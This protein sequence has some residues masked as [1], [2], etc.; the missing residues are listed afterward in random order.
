M[1]AMPM[2]PVTLVQGSGSFTDPGPPPVAGYTSWYDP[3]DYTTVTKSGDAVSS[4]RD[5]GSGG[6]TLTPNIGMPLCTPQGKPG[7]SAFYSNAGAFWSSN[8]DMTDISSSFF[9]VACNTFF[10]GAGRVLLGPTGNSGISFYPANT[11]QLNVDSSGVIQIARMTAAMTVG[12]PY[13]AGL[14]LSASTWAM[15]LNNIRESGAHAVGLSGGRTLQVG[16]AANSPSMVGW[17]GDIV[18]YPSTLSDGDADLVINW[19]ISKW[20]IA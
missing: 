9:C 18:V 2:M 3:S 4:I 14:V 11:Q 20:G 15:T 8:V 7:R 13:V 17:I 1:S 5:K 6:F 16:A 10:G 12:R 19:L